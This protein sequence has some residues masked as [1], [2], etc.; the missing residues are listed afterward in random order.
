MK[1]YRFA[2]RSFFAAVGGAF[3]LKILLRNIEAVA[4]GA[5]SPPR[6]LLTHWPVGTVR[7]QWLP[8]GTGTGYTTSPILKPFEDAG[9]RE[10]M[11]ALYGLSHSG[12]NTGG[13]G[14]HE[15]GT[16]MMSTGANCPGTRSNGGE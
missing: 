7:T 12:I 14:G 11:I 15:A 8:T 10:D 9:L 3:G 1:S 6:F 16:P 2:R 13:G 4:Q 5:T